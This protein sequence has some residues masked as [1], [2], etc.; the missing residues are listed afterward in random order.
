MKNLFYLTILFALLLSVSA[1]G[2]SQLE[3]VSGPATVIE[4]METAW[5]AQDLEAV[6]ALYT[7]DAVETNRLGKFT[8]KEE[9]RKLFGPII[10]EFTM[11]C[12][13]YAVNGN[14]VS[15][16]CV[17]TRKGG[18]TLAG[19]KYDA[20]IENGKIKANTFTGNFSP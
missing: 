6:L 15:Y 16:E 17:L 8:G 4:A 20:V 19:E 2:S 1:C 12:G 3:E 18:T 7:D 10:D 11:E 14:T 13:N 5:N 9:L